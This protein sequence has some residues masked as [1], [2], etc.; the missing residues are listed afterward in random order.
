MKGLVKSFD[1]LPKLV[2]IILALPVLAIAWAIYRLARSINKK[3]TLGIVLAIIMIFVNAAVFWIVDI[4]TIILADRVLW[5][6]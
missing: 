2:K 5:I 1:K 6:D 3:N 4:I